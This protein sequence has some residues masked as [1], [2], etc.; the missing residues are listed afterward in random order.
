MPYSIN[1]QGRETPQPIRGN[2]ADKTFRCNIIFNDGNPAIT[3]E[4][5]ANNPPQARKRAE[6]RFGGKC[7]SANQVH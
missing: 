1:V 4:V 6:A 5:E 7:T 2:M 3:E